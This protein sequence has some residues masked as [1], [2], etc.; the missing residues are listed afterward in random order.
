EIEE[1]DVFIKVV[2]S[3]HVLPGPQE[4]GNIGSFWP[5]FGALSFRKEYRFPQHLDMFQFRIFLDWKGCNT[6]ISARF[7]LHLDVSN[8]VATYDVPFGA[9]ARRPY[10]EVPFD[11]EFTM[12]PVVDGVLA[13]AKGDWPALHWVD[14]GDRVGGLSM[15]NT[16]TP[17]HQL[18]SGEI[19]VSLLRSPTRR[20]DGAM[21]P[22]PG[23]YDE[24]VHSYDFAFRPRLPNEMEKAVELGRRLNRPPIAV[25]SAGA[26]GAPLKATSMVRWNA[27][28]IVL[29][30]FKR[31]L[32]GSSWILRLYE[33]LGRK[34]VTEL[35]SDYGPLVAEETDFAE[36]TF[37]RMPGTT[38]SFRPFEIKTLRLIPGPGPHRVSGSRPKPRK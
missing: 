37:I 5:G 35:C 21:V 7:P 17:G 1:G 28:N 27:D 31:S 23:A 32:D 19:L 15:A 29:S 22:Q 3:G 6:K 8:A 13:H 20:A 38:L 16:G 33:T 30:A 11:Q 26:G 4:P 34:T 18:K 2:T 24:G 12:Q 25:Y 14:Y 10:F 36:K 9:L